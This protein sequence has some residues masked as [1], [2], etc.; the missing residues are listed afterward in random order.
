MSLPSEHENNIKMNLITNT[1]TKRNA[2]INA[3]LTMNIFE[4]TNGCIRYWLAPLLGQSDIGIDFNVD[5]MSN[6]ILE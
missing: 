3:K 2:D 5:I 4:R 1:K 6:L